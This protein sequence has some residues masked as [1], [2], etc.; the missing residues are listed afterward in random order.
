MWTLLLGYSFS[1][2]FEE[3]FYKLFKNDF[4]YR[5]VISCDRYLTY[6]EAGVGWLYLEHVKLKYDLTGAKKFILEYEFRCEILTQIL[7]VLK[8]F[9]TYM[10]I[11]SILE[12]FIDNFFFI[13]HV[14][15]R[16]L[17]IHSS[18][19]NIS[20]KNVYGLFLILYFL[21]LF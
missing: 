15:G 4:S 5:N 12:F 17:L 16:Y 18:S 9:C 3:S 11:L 19:S 14:T 7:F 6:L 1:V 21:I 8:Y 10:H 20:V 2:I 13:F